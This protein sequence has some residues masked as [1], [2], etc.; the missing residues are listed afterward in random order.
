ME[1]RIK[2]FFEQYILALHRQTSGNARQFLDMSFRQSRGSYFCEPQHPDL[3]FLNNIP[4]ESPAKLSEY[5]IEFWKNEP[6]LQKMVPD[7]VKLAFELKE[8][9]KEQSAELSPFVYAMF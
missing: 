4:F 5:L 8:E 9:E 7:L 6:Q 1:K 2:K 3:L